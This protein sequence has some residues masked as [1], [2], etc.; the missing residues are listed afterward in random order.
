MGSWPGVLLRRMRPFLAHLGPALGRR[1]RQ[2]SG[3]LRSRLARVEVGKT[4]L[5]KSVLPRMSGCPS[6]SNSTDIIH[7]HIFLSG[8]EI[9]S[10]NSQSGLLC[11]TS[12]PHPACG[13]KE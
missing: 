12:P 1:A 2:V 9:L 4:P 7:Q 10:R 3:V 8:N 6:L 5:W 11:R 13:E